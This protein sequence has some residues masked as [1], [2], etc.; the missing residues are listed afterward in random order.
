MLETAEEKIEKMIQRVDAQ[1]VQNET[2]PYALKPEIDITCT[3]DQIE[4][5]LSNILTALIQ[6]AGR[7]CDAYASDLFIWWKNINKQICDTDDKRTKHILLGYYNNG[8][9]DQR[10]IINKINEYKTCPIAYL[11]RK[12]HMIRVEHTINANNEPV[13]NMQLY[14][15][16]I[17]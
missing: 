8:V 1:C 14:S 15:N 11:Y 3:C 6:A 7:Y 9:D 16:C 5:E 13:I 10:S 17:R 2:D 4:N 12:I